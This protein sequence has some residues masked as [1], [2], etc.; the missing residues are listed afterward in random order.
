MRQQGGQKKGPEK[1]GGKVGERSGSRHM[2]LIANQVFPAPARV[3]CPVSVCLPEGP[4]LLVPCKP[5]AS[6]PTR[7]PHS[8]P[9]LG[10]SP[11]S[12]LLASSIHHSGLFIH[13][14]GLSPS[15]PHV[16]SS[17]YTKCFLKAKTVLEISYYF[18]NHIERWCSGNTCSR[19]SERRRPR[20]SE[21]R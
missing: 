3:D 21:D 15:N 8:P 11:S 14:V 4:H 13:P 17:C 18:P 2:G 10:N 5:L 9:S 16:L 19:R 6:S 7:H 12:P 1:S 20:L